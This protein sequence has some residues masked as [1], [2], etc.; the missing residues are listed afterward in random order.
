MTRPLGLTLEIVPDRNPYALRAGEELPVRVYYR[1]APLP[2]ARVT[3]TDLRADDRPA[4]VRRTDGQG[5][6][7]F[8]MRPGAWMLNVVWSNPSERD[9]RADFET[10]FSSLTFGP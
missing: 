8:P 9:P 1:G 6:A 2:G 7:R 5:R 4:A 3:M 10:I